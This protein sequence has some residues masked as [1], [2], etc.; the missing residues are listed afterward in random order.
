MGGEEASCS[1]EP[2]SCLKEVTTKPNKIKKTV[3]CP[4]SS[5]CLSRPFR[6]DHSLKRVLLVRRSCVILT[7]K[8]RSP[9]HPWSCGSCRKNGPGD[10]PASLAIRWTQLLRGPSQPHRPFS[11][12]RE[13][14]KKEPQLL[15]GIEDNLTTSPSSPALFSCPAKGTPRCRSWGDLRT[16]LRLASR[17][18]CGGP[19]SGV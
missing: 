18:T 1:D 8:K 4:V 17:V 16:I 7:P 6:S 2:S 5:S 12:D 14:K 10:L 19:V 9:F 3:P 13:K 11:V 15:M